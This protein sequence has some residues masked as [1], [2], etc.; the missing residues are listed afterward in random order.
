[1][2]KQVLAE[3]EDQEIDAPEGP[4]A[5]GVRFGRFQIVGVL[6]RGGMATVYEA[7]EAPPLERTVALK[8]LPPTLLDHESFRARFTHEAK[9]VARLEHPGIVPIYASGIDEGLPW[10]SMRLMRDGTLAA[11]LGRGLGI[12]RTTRILRGV[13]EAL[14]YAHASGVLHRDIK[15]HN[16][17]LDATGRG[18]LND[19]GLARLLERPE[20]WTGTGTV[21]G[22]P[23]Y[24][25][26]EQA[27]GMPINRASDLYSLGVVAYEMLTGV[28]P[29]RGDSPVAIGKRH[30]DEALP[31]PARELVPGAVFGVLQKALAKRSAERWPSAIAFVDALEAAGDLRPAPAGR[32]RTAAVV[33]LVVIAATAVAGLWVITPRPARPAPLLLSRT[34]AT[35]WNLLPDAPEPGKLPIPGPSSRES[36]TST[37]PENI[38]AVVTVTPTPPAEGNEASGA[39]APDL[40]PDV[41]PGAGVPPPSGG[42]VDAV[43]PSPAVVDARDVFVEAKQIVQVRPTYPPIARARQIEGDVVLRGF[44]GVDGTVSSI[45]VVEPAHAILNRA[46]LEAFSQ[47]RYEPATRN[48]TPVPSPVRVTVSFKLK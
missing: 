34:F 31:V 40:L 30:V 9:L 26:P 25:S 6:G 5:P 19:F 8:V 42:G 16:I 12:E 20:A 41:P 47:F 44:V 10:M 28:P 22:T 1:L 36:D 7:R 35:V 23:H 39:K 2:L 33:S 32:W 4:L 45:T 27:L 13:A 11:L 38:T 43:K 29:F 46:A 24:M 37:P 48:G 21:A 3:D 17:L 18:C 14:D 15:P